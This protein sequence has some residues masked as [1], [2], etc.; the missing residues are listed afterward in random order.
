MST[1]AGVRSEGRPDTAHPT[2]RLIPTTRAATFTNSVEACRRNR[3]DFE[4]AIHP[5][6]DIKWNE[7]DYQNLKVN[8][9]NHMYDLGVRSFAIHFDDI[10]GEGTDSNKQVDLLNRLTKEFV[11]TKG[12]VA[13]LVVCPTD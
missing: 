2:V 3:V 7:E 6:K 10:E 9:F 12:D 13:P 1:R 11:K 8:K 4:G 5:G